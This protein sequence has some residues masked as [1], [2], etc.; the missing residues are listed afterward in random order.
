L[1][2][3]GIHPLAIDLSSVCVAH[4]DFPV[5]HESVIEDEGRER[6]R[7]APLEGITKQ[8]SQLREVRVNYLILVVLR[9]QRERLNHLFDGTFGSDTI[10][11]AGNILAVTR[12][13]A[14]HIRSLQMAMRRFG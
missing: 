14:E 9:R 6:L 12:I 4:P 11:I 1:L 10:E 5:V 3:P 13:G 2:S 7:V 8:G